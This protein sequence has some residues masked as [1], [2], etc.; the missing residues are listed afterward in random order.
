MESKWLTKQVRKKV[1]EQFRGCSGYKAISSVLNTS[2][3][4]VHQRRKYYSTHAKAL[5][6]LSVLEPLQTHSTIHTTVS[7]LTAFAFR[8]NHLWCVGMYT[9]EKRRRKE[10]KIKGNFLTA[11]FLLICVHCISISHTSFLFPSPHDL[12]QC[13]LNFNVFRVTF[14]LGLS[15]PDCTAT[16]PQIWRSTKIFI[17]S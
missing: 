11:S 12:S 1:V 5:T 8:D 14:L 10:L 3:S 2:Q 13:F 9:Q 17:R 15:L 7:N 6:Y 16:K 4:I